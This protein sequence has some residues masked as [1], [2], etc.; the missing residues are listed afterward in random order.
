MTRTSSGIALVVFVALAVGV[1]AEF[2][3]LN[4]PVLVSI[5]LPAIAGATWLVAGARATPLA[6]AAT[7][8]V[9]GVA[10]GLALGV[11]GEGSY[12]ALHF[13]R[14]GELSFEGYDSQRAMAL[15]LLAIHTLVGLGGGALAGTLVAAT[16]AARGVVLR[17][18]AR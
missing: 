3:D 18:A 12:L 8:L 14:G 11:I 2:A 17:R 7:A 16:F 15:A 1:A 4:Q 13:A 10:L 6:R 5:A 9:A